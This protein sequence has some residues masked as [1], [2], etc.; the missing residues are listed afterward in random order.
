[1]ITEQD[2]K[3][4]PDLWDELTD[5]DRTLWAILNNTRGQLD[6]ATHTHILSAVD[7]I[8]NALMLNKC[9]RTNRGRHKIV[10]CA[11]QRNP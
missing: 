9:H 8:F 4:I 11:A 2:R 7:H 6:N 10:K 5:L 1:M 3:A